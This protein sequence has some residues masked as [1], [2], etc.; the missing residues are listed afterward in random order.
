MDY[1][2]GEIRIFGGTYAPEGW[3]NC[4]GQLVAISDNDAL[5]SLLGTTYGG[6]GQTTFGLPDLRS[7]VPVGVGQSASSGNNYVRGQ[8]VGVENVT[9]TTLQMPVHQHPLQASIKA[10]TNGTAQASPSQAYFGDKGG[11][12][13]AAEVG[14]SKLAND[15]VSGTLTPAGSSGNHTNMQPTL[16]V[17]YIIAMTGIYPSEP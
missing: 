9:L 17:R 7:R 3:Q 16:T 2:L 11:D 1:Y 4:D 8:K 6:D 14:T 10:V 12:T 13:Y 15:A 5:Y